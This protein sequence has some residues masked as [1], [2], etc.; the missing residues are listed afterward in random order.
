MDFKMNKFIERLK[1]VLQSA[2]QPMGFR[3]ANN[4]ASRPRIQLVARVDG[5]FKTLASRLT[6]AD[7]LILPVFQQG[8]K[9]IIW[10]LQIDEG[11]VEEATQ[12]KKAGADFVV[13]NIGGTVLPPEPEI[14]KILKVDAAITDTM[15]R[16]LNELPLDAFLVEDKENGQTFSWQRLILIHRFAGFFNKPLLISVPLTVTADELKIIWE[17]GVSGVAVDIGSEADATALKNL[18][19]IINKLPFPVQKKKKLTP[20]LP[21]IVEEAPHEEPDEDDDDD[22]DG[23]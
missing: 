1:Q 12:A 2:P 22:D 4:V 13:F 17:A 7:A 19:Q 23:D 15:L 21:H 6:S 9:D 3:T 8:N 14:G 16:T 10:G 11:S 20:T 5:S 18:R